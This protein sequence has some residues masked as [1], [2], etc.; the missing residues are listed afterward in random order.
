MN[1]TLELKNLIRRKFGKET[2]LATTL[3]WP[4]QRLNKITTGKKTPNI[5]ELNALAIALEEPVDRML[6]LFLTKRSPNEQ[7]HPP[8][9]R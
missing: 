3:G 5:E 2:R 6:F 1:E 7:Q 4:R 9:R 8:E